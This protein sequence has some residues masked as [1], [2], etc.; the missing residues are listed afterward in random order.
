VQLIHQMVVNNHML[1]S[2]IATLAS[3]RKMAER[4]ASDKFQPII[5]ASVDHLEVAADYVRQRPAEHR[6]VSAE[7][8]FVIREELKQLLEQR[9]KEVAEGEL[10]TSTR[11]RFSELK[12]IADQFEYINKISMELEKLG[13]RLQG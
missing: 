9:L 8:N 4:Y 1:A 2:H 10:D 11:Q 3:Y 13:A 7:E 5:Q 12:T 6:V